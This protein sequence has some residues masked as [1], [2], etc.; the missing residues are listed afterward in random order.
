M[1]ATQYIAEQ[2]ILEAY[3]N[4]AFE[5]L[6]GFG[7]PVDNTHYFSVP[8][9]YRMAFHILE[10]AGLLNNKAG[11]APGTGS[12]DDH[13]N[14]SLHESDTDGKLFKMQKVAFHQVVIRGK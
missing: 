4:G 12:N 11:S 10:N 3:E 14:E 2:R 5:H 1:E 8:P 13:E 7:S 6:E 9:E